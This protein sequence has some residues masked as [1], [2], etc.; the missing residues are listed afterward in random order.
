MPEVK[1]SRTEKNRGKG[2]ALKESFRQ[3]RGRYVAFLDSDLDIHPRQ[4]RVLMDVMEK[5]GADVVIGCKRHPESELHYPAVRK[6]LS[7]GYFL[8]ARLLFGLPVRDTQTG[9]KLFKHEVL[10][11]VLPEVRVEHYAFDLELLVKLHQRGC[12]IAEAPVVV[13]FKGRFGRIGFRD[14]V[15]MFFHTLETFYRLRLARKS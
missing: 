5:T 2:G 8:L 13:D 15:V 3:A 12:R 14:I 10:D 1:A 9:V 6:V 7:W 11:P 4:F